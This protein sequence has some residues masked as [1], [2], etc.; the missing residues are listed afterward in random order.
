MHGH[1]PRGATDGHT[2]SSG[3]MLT[4]VLYD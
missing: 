2:F 3:L 1:E 4:H